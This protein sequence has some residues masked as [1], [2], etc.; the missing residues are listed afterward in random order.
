MPL[1]VTIPVLPCRGGPEV[2]RRVFEP[3]GWAVAA[4]P[5][6]LDEAFP[7]WGDSRYVRL[8]LRGAVRLADS[9]NQL[10]VLL[11]VLDESKHYWQGPDEVDKLLRSGGG[12]LASH[13][14]KDLIARRYLG[15]RGGLARVALSRLAELGDE[16]EE[17]I[18][19]AED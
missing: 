3:L 19:P 18:E 1:E 16:V 4:E 2:A 14:A 9:L 15:R 12:W 13:P 6:A 8:C 10:Y 5:I 7:E 17:T 11:P